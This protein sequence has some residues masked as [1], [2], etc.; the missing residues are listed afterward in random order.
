MSNDVTP[1]NYQEILAQIK[2]EIANSQ[3]RAVQAVNK[4][5]I[6]LYWHIGKIILENSEWGNKYIDNLAIDLKLEFPNIEGFSV[7]NLKYMKKLASEYPDFEF[8]QEVLAQITWYHNLIL[9]DKIK[10]I[11]TTEN[12]YISSTSDSRIK[13]SNIFDNISKSKVI[14]N[15]VEYKQGNLIKLCK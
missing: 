8:V 14:D 12:Y 15:I 13:A 1:N 11:E 4:E 3:Y 6:Y 10:N 9:M 5:L 7:R 2:N